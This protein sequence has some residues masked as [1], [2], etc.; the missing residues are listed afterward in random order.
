M[1]HCAKCGTLIDQ[2]TR[3]CACFEVPDMD[4]DANDEPADGYAP[5]AARGEPD[6]CERANTADR[7][8]FIRENAVALVRE[9]EGKVERQRRELTKLHQAKAD[10][11]ADLQR[12]FASTA[13]VKLGRTVDEVCDKGI[14]ASDEL[15]TLRDEN[16]ELRAA[17]KPF[18]DA[19]ASVGNCGD[20]VG[21]WAAGFW[22]DYDNAVTV[23]DFKRAA[24]LLL[25]A[26]GSP[27][28]EGGKGEGE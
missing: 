24:R 16:A 19:L 20:G 23:A 13:H 11:R 21:Q 4:D 5:L 18:A 10:L 26:N 3:W 27:A 7:E 6:A 25:A 15:V 1:S 22:K 28:A 17:L 2:R 9:L 14:R 12:L 8:R